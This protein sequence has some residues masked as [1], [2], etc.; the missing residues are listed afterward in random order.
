M[1]RNEQKQVLPVA[2]LNRI[3]HAYDARVVT[4]TA[5]RPSLKSERMDGCFAM[6]LPNPLNQHIFYFRAF[7]LF[8]KSAYLTWKTK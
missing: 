4:G 8:G 1:H 2:L 6:A 5:F 3:Y 7:P